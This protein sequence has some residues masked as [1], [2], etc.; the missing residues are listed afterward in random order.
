MCRI[1]IKVLYIAYINK[2]NKFIAVFKTYNLDKKIDT[3]YY[4]NKVI[5]VH[6]KKMKKTKKDSE[7]RKY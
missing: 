4:G 1:V 7:K 5:H 6:K 2:T 3:C